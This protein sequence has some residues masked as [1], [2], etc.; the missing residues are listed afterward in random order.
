MEE[1]EGNLSRVYT[2]GYINIDLLY[3]TKLQLYLSLLLSVK[4]QAKLRFPSLSELKR[5]NNAL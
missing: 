3:I 1:G 5:R 2:Y 4:A